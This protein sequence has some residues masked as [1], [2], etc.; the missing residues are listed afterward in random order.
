MRCQDCKKDKADS[1]SFLTVWERVKL[2]LFN[3][4][5]EEITDLSA[6]KFTAG[7]GVGYTLGFNA[8]RELASEHICPT[9]EPPKQPI[10]LDYQV[11]LHKVFEVTKDRKMLLGGRVLEPTEIAEFQSQATVLSQ[12]PLWAVMQES[13]KQKA[14]EGGLLRSEK[15]EDTLSSKAMLHN[16]GVQRSII[17]ILL[18][19]QTK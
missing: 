8:A 17:D 11:D 4:F 15:W 5:H 13:L 10:P 9:F 14:I 3:K 19:Y 16:L 1:D 2:F 12:I 18:N 7:V 6:E